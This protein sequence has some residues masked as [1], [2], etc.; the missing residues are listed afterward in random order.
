MVRFRSLRLSE[1]IHFLRK[2]RRRQ[3]SILWDIRSYRM[4]AD[5][6]GSCVCLCECVCIYAHSHLYIMFFD[7]ESYSKIIIRKVYLFLI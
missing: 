7:S 5:N 4:Y 2:A 1:A 6:V 3:Q